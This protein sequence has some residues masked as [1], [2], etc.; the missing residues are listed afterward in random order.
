M[1][2]YYTQLSLFWLL[3]QIHNLFTTVNKHQAS[4]LCPANNSTN[5]LIHS[6]EGFSLFAIVKCQSGWDYVLGGVSS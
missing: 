2:V 5:L 4:P 1:N 6:D 3:A